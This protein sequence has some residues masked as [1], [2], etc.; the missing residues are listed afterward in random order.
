MSPFGFFLS[1]GDLGLNN[2]ITYLGKFELVVVGA[3]HNMELLVAVLGCKQGSLPMKYLG[4]PLGA[5]FKDKSIWNPILEKMERKLAGGKKLYL[6]KGGRVT[7][8]KSTLSNL[9]TYFLSLFPIPASVANRIARLQR[10]FLWGSLGDKPK[11][12]LVDWS[13]VCTL[14]ASGGLGIR[15]LRTFNVALLGKWL[16]RFGQ[17]RDALWCQVI[18]VKYDC[19]WSGW[20]SSSSFAPHGVSFW[21]NIRRGWHSLSRFFLY[22]IG[23]GSKVQFWVDS[24]CGSSSLVDR[25]PGLF[26]FCRRKEASV[27]DLM[28]FTNG[29]VHWE[30]HFCRD[31]HNRELEAFR[32]PI[33]EKMERKLAGWKKLYLSKRGRVTL[34]KSTLS[35]LPTYFLSLFP[36]P[37]SVANRIAR[38]QRDFLWGSLGDE[39]KFHLVDWPTV[40]TLLASGGLGIRNLKTFNVALLGKWLWRFGQERDALWR[41]VI[42]VKYGCDWGGWCSSSSSAPHGVSFWKNIRRGWHS[43]SRLFLYEIGDGSKV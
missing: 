40:C 33:L 27:T 16:W 1:L 12:H 19:D 25:Y 22:E 18:E 20:C 5:K 11:F 13:M 42:E 28:R 31:V 8:I 23:D 24:W 14:L 43:L 26:R 38:F 32:N 7:L 39:P 41:Q 9:P 17:E 29:V 6:S 35:N 10:D 15:N 2:Y 3:V 34:I 4:L 36:I 30:I 21:K 37:A